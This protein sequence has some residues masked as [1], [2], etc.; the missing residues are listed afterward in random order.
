MLTFSAETASH[1]FRL[2]ITRDLV[3]VLGEPQNF[4]IFVLPDVAVYIVCNIEK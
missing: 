2:N 3:A 1:E 4:D